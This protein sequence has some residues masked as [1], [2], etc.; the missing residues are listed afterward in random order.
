MVSALEPEAERPGVILNH[1]G[2]EIGRHRGIIHYTMGQRKGL[3]I[4]NPEPLY[5]LKV[6]AANNT[7]I[8]GPRELAYRQEITVTNINWL[9]AREYS[10]E[11]SVKIRSTAP[12]IPALVKIDKQEGNKAVV[13]F[14]E[15]AFAPA[16]GQSA[17]FYEGDTV[18]G[19]GEI[20]A[21][22]TLY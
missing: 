4:S 14:K 6:D 15:P 19:G 8:V 18:T 2:K 1:E 7:V 16:P 22:G 9:E 20:G 21:T 12:G 10:F 5:V 13:H 3:G 11:A 17:V